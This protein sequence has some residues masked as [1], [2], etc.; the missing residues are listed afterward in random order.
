MI[1][2]IPSMR[3]QVATQPADCRKG[4]DGCATSVERLCVNPFS[5]TVFVFSNILVWNGDMGGVRCAQEGLRI[6]ICRFER[7]KHEALRQEIS[8]GWPLAATFVH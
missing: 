1:A 5:G 3:L 8:R 4:I 7:A 6:A 2:M